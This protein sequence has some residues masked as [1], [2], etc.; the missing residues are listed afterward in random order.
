MTS[1][2]HP[3]MPLSQRERRVVPFL[4]LMRKQGWQLSRISG[5]HHVH[6]REGRRS[7]PVV[8]HNRCVRRDVARQVLRQAGIVESDRLFAEVETDWVQIES[9]PPGSP[10]SS[11]GGTASRQRDEAA[12]DLS[13]SVQQEQAEFDPPPRLPG[14]VVLATEEDLDAVQELKRK[15][16]REQ[17]RQA[18]AFAA[19][20]LDISRKLADSE[21]ST[22]EIKSALAKLEQLQ[23]Q[24]AAGPAFV[25]Y[26]PRE[27]LLADPEICSDEE[28]HHSAR[29]DA[30]ELQTHQLEQLVLDIVFLRSTSLLE[31]AL[32]QPFG[33]PEQMQNIRGAF[34]IVKDTKRTTHWRSTHKHKFDAFHTGLVQHLFSRFLDDVHRCTKHSAKGKT[35]VSLGYTTEAEQIQMGKPSVEVDP[36]TYERS[37]RSLRK[38]LSLFLD[39]FDENL[40]A[41][42][43]VLFHR[44]CPSGTPQDRANVFAQRFS[45]AS[46]RSLNYMLVKDGVAATADRSAVRYMVRL[47][48]FL[49]AHKIFELLTVVDNAARFP[50]V[51]EH[52]RKLQITAVR[53]DRER[54]GRIRDGDVGRRAGTTSDT[55]L[56]SSLDDVWNPY[57]N[58]SARQIGAK[59]GD[60]FRPPVG[61]ADEVLDL[62]EMLAGS[63]STWALAHAYQQALRDSAQDLQS[64]DGTPSSHSQRQQDASFSPRAGRG[65][66]SPRATPAKVFEHLANHDVPL[67]LGIDWVDFVDERIPSDFAEVRPEHLGLIMEKRVFGGLEDG[68]IPPVYDAAGAG[69]ERTDLYDEKKVCEALERGRHRYLTYKYSPVSQE[70]IVVDCA[71]FHEK[72]EKLNTIWVDELGMWDGAGYDKSEDCDSSDSE[73]TQMKT[74]LQFRRGERQLFGSTR[75]KTWPAV[76]EFL[77]T[78]IQTLHSFPYPVFWRGRSDF[79]LPWLLVS[80]VPLICFP[81]CRGCRSCP[82]HAHTPHDHPDLG[83]SV[84]H[85]ARYMRGRERLASHVKFL[86]DNLGLVL[87]NSVFHHRSPCCNRLKMEIV[88]FSSAVSTC[89]CAVSTNSIAS[90]TRSSNRTTSSSTTSA[91]SFSRYTVRPT[92]STRRIFSTFATPALCNFG[93]FKCR[94]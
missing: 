58:M 84:S 24:V 23:R 35:A 20:F 8:V 85:P 32:E 59:L 87:C 39:L 2:A 38:A 82:C 6:V 31:L 29:T 93:F 4:N 79:A 36:K 17:T 49:E 28:Q 65:E 45:I 11:D 73:L 83:G 55:V 37:L 27:F 12:H 1:A 63:H 33:S 62:R 90:T 18:D 48:K 46:H 54:A 3:R 7:I 89:S 72:L 92:N 94:R 50:S 47:G 5:S 66:R 75:K 67:I 41:V 86:H 14:P 68:Q 22:E 61:L 53:S 51:E 80:V 25:C 26:L 81:M 42:E 10:S 15:E 44:F 74:S 19:E 34:Q 52:D 13:D 91:S 43:T 78:T 71:E 77:Q 21:S 16:R 40:V 76:Q 69:G 88:I 60:C 30:P 56:S 9:S 64:E 57:L 70:R